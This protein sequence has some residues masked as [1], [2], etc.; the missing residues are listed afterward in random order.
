MTVRRTKIDCCNGCTDRQADPNCHG[1]CE[2]Y[3]KEKAEL[4]ESNAEKAKLRNIVSGL[5]QQSYD[6]YSRVTKYIHY[7]SKYRKPR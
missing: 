4:E 1:F 3:L 5:Q 7:R 2:R 6:C